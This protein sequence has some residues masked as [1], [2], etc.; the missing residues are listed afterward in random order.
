[1]T[2]R[3]KSIPRFSPGARS[4]RLKHVVEQVLESDP[5][6][7]LYISVLQHFGND[8]NKFNVIDYFLRDMTLFES[9]TCAEAVIDSPNEAD[10]AKVISRLE[11]CPVPNYLRA[12]CIFFK[13]FL[14]DKKNDGQDLNCE[15]LYVGLTLDELMTRKATEMTMNTTSPRVAKSR[16]LVADFKKGIKRDP[17][18]LPSLKHVDN[19]PTF[20]REAVAQARAQG[21][22]D[23]LNPKRK[24]RGSEERELFALQLYYVY[25]IFCSS[26]KADFGRKLARDHESSQDAQAIWAKLSNDAEKSTVAQLNATDLLQRVRAARVESWK[27]ATL[28]L[29][30]RCQEQ[31]RLRDQLQPPNEQTSDHA[32]M[33]YLQ[34][35]A[36]AIEELRLAQTAGSQ[37]ALA[38][39]AAPAHK[40]YEARTDHQGSPQ[41]HV[42]RRHPIH[43]RRRHLHPQPVPRSRRRH[44]LGPQ[45]LPLHGR[46]C[47]DCGRVDDADQ[48]ERAV[49][50][51]VLADDVPLRHRSLHDA[52][53]HLRRSGHPLVPA[54]RS[55]K[56]MAGHDQPVARGALLAATED[57]GPRRRMVGRGRRCGRATR[58]GTLRAAAGPGRAATCPVRYQGRGGLHDRYPAVQL[59]DGPQWKPEGEVVDG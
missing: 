48:D 43:R 28:S 25:A 41:H 38:N 51:H 29:A 58:G 57:S 39:G 45:L 14:E 36:H 32:K 24:P 20:K 17:P 33:I 54:L 8:E 3:S 23:V 49:S 4:A 19:W 44:P 22:I 18:Q 55:G 50:A 21:V 9:L 15:S 16:D 2:A 1:M 35:A 7:P 31:I 30:L 52:E 11:V 12:R 34:S 13:R 26:L 56:G 27:G 47:R 37:L 40:D 46:T 42:E 53:A 5:S 6:S 10:P 59:A